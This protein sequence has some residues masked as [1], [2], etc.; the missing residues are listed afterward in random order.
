MRKGQKAPERRQLRSSLR[1]TA[2]FM[3]GAIRVA[4]ARVQSGTEVGWPD[5]RPDHVEQLLT[6]SGIAVSHW[7]LPVDDF[8]R[9]LERADYPDSYYGGTLSPEPGFHEKALEHFVSLALAAPDAG[10]VVIDVASHGGPFVDIVKE[11]FGSTCYQQ[12]LE[13]PTGVQGEMI[14]GNAADMPVP[15]GFADVMTLHCSYDHFEDSAD[16]G[17]A[18]EAGRVL[19]EGGR[20]VVV[21][22]YLSDTFGVKMDPQLRRR[23]IALD[24]GMRRFLIPGLRVE[25][26]RLY[27]PPRLK[28]RVLDPAEQAGLTWEMIRVD[29]VAE[30]V[31]HGYCH[32]ALVL[33]KRGAGDAAHSTPTG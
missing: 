24:P 21:P 30:A 12:D 29:G 17:F 4:L 2:R 23:D 18:R 1:G 19:R 8:G 15:D 28:E 13:F 33:R 11:I 25:F 20:V 14:G 27:D 6:S 5:E 3:R 26:S 22:L 31:P 9:Y 16:V 7:R 32:F 10:D